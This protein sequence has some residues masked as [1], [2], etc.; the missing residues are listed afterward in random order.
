MSEQDHRRLSGLR[1]MMVMSGWVRKR[2][3]YF[4]LTR[5]GQKIAEKGF[6]A[7]HFL[8]LMEIYIRQF[9]WAYEDRY[10]EL[11]IIQEAALFSLYLLRMKAADPVHSDLLGDFFIRA[12]PATPGETEVYAYSTP[13]E[14]VRNAFTLRFIERFGEYFGLLTITRKKKE[15]R[16]RD[17]IYAKITPFFRKLFQWK[18]PVPE[19]SGRGF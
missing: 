5:E 2:N 12:F 13:E 14:M 19:E 11:G 3:Q 10:P 17:D 1:H 15:N 6:E 16:W 7:K 4:S 18:L 9:N 8:R